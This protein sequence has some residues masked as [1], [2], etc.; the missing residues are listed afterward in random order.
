MF[1]V[2]LDD[3]NMK[4]CNERTRT[5][6]N[7]THVYYCFF[8][9]SEKAVNVIKQNCLRADQKIEYLSLDLTKGK[10]EIYKSFKE[11]EEKSGEIYMLVNNAGMAICGTID[12]TKSSDAE[13]LMNLNFF[14]TLYPIQYVLP[15]M[16]SRKDGIIVLTASQAALLGIFG[17][18]VY[19]ATK[20][21]LRGLAGKIIRNKILYCL[22]LQKSIS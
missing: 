6:F 4:Q 3:K 15:K 5:A 11:I 1:I 13:W 17:L 2:Q 20:F 22:Y 19:S 21:A 18:G 12:N 8:I 16:K 10:D 14:G 9:F 7:Q